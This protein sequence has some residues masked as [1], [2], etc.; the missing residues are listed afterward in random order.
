MAEYRNTPVSRAELE[1]KST[2]RNGKHLVFSDNGRCKISSRPGF[3]QFY[4]EWSDDRNTHYARKSLLGRSFDY[5][6]LALP[7]APPNL[8]Q[9]LYNH[10]TNPDT[11]LRIAPRH[12]R[13]RPS[14]KFQ[15]QSF[16]SRRESRRRSRRRQSRRRTKR[17]RSRKRSRKR[18]RKRRRA[19]A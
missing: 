11:L 7:G 5:R 1:A 18:R 10:L 13:G 19:N 16:A 8:R 2:A 17:S 4:C 3:G 15:K 6:I 9:D 14:K 12:Y